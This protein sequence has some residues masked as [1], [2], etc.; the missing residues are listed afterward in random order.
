MIRCPLTHLAR[1]GSER[2][3][4]LKDNPLDDAGADAKRP[5]N[6]EDTV[7]LGSEFP[8]PGLHGR[9]DLPPAELR[10][11]LTCPRQPGV[12]ALPN[13]ASFKFHKALSSKLLAPLNRLC[14][15]CVGKSIAAPPLLPREGEPPIGHQWNLSSP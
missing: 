9:L 10:A 6:L 15:H 8:Y 2:S 12:N 3:Y 7:A 4:G 13:Y 11:V 1:S 5:T 14:R